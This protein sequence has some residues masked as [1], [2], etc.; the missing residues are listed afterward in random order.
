MLHSYYRRMIRL[1]SRGRNNLLIPILGA[2]RR[3]NECLFLN[4]YLCVSSGSKLLAKFYQFFLSLK[5]HLQSPVLV[6]N[7]CLL[8]CTNL[9]YP[10]LVQK[11][12]LL[13]QLVTKLIGPTFSLLFTYLFAECLQD[14]TFLFQKFP[15][16]ND[17]IPYLI[18]LVIHLNDCHA[19]FLNLYLQSL[20]NFVNLFLLIKH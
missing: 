19:I 17:F 12:L 6:L 10:L 8:N 1:F 15:Q 16:S 5:L 2:S 20:L 18:A 7:L 9:S 13:F 11:F 14:Q 4:W 3:V